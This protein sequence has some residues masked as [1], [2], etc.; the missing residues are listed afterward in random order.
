M[1]RVNFKELNLSLSEVLSRQDMKKIRGGYT[2]DACAGK[3]ST[4]VC[5]DCNNQNLGDI[6]ATGCDRTTVEN[7]CGK[8][9]PT[10]CLQDT[11]CSCTG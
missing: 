9:Y 11:T 5:R 4:I 3:P 8:Q 7:A 1:K 2:G 10:Y 6:S